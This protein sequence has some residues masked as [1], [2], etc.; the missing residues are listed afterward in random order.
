M[1]PADHPTLDLQP[2]RGSP[3]SVTPAG[4]Q[5]MPVSGEHVL[6]REI[7]PALD[8]REVHAQLG[9]KQS[10]RKHRPVPSRHGHRR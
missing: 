8:L 7:V 1:V 5:L 3:R 4:G 10:L 2:E 6:L 9:C